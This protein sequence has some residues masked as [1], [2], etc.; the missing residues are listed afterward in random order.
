M[1]P[2]AGLLISAGVHVSRHKSLESPYGTICS[3]VGKGIDVE[4]LFSEDP[5]PPTRL[6]LHSF[7]PTKLG[8]RRISKRTTM[9]VTTASR[10]SEKPKPVPVI[11]SAHSGLLWS[12]Y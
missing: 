2:K 10:G 8:N 9:P 7:T 11:V 1:A 4:A 6:R 12:A 5:G 3:E